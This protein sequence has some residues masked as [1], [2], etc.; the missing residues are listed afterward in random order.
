MPYQGSW[1]SITE[2]CAML[3]CSPPTFYKYRRVHPDFPTRNEF[4]KYLDIDVLAWAA[5]H[6]IRT[7]KIVRG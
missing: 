7:A 5:K 3:G 2:V 1:V 6:A 4:N